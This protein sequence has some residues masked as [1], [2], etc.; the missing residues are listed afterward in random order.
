M[1]VADWPFRSMGR[2]REVTFST[3]SIMIDAPLWIAHCWEGI[4]IGLASSSRSV[5]E[6]FHNVEASTYVLNFDI[7][8]P[9]QN[10][11][12]RHRKAAAKSGSYWLT[13]SG[14]LAA[15][16]FSYI[17][18]DVVLA[19]LD[20]TGVS[21]FVIICQPAI[22]IISMVTEV[23]MPTDLQRGAA[24]HSLGFEDKNLGSSPGW[25]AATVATYCPSRPG[26][27][28]KFLSSKPCE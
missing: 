24:Y 2:E 12:N 13:S 18:G 28:H 1:N 5:F 14:Q 6:A 16:I 3:S 19:N 26:E 15:F 27:L 11:H 25:W 4:V 23:G 7:A 9:P 17:E 8:P 22:V 10:H 21:R 20:E